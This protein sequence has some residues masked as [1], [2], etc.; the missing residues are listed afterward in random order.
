M[1]VTTARRTRT[2]PRRR[3]EARALFR[4]AIIEAAEAVFAER[5]FHGARIQDIAERAKVAVGTVYNHFEQKEDV[6]RALLDERTEEMLAE[7]R[8]RPDD[9]REVEPRLIACVGRMLTYVETH[10]DFFAIAIEHGLIGVSTTAARQILGGKAPKHVEKFRAAFVELMRD[11]VSRGEL[12]PPDPIRLARC[13]GGIIRGFTIGALSE[14]AKKNA[15][16]ANESE[17]IVHLFLRG[18]SARPSRATPTTPPSRK[19]R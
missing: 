3:D 16:L 4:N 10:R 1:N 15:P 19:R 9:P 7:L 11:A 17:L 5:G 6:L 14:D 12:S 13:L 8:A 18:A 2:T